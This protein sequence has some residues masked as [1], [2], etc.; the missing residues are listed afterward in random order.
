M[1]RAG[2]RFYVMGVPAPHSPICLPQTSPLS[3]GLVERATACVDTAG[4]R[5]RNEHIVTEE[6]CCT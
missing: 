4:E 3:P 5:S 1:L 6:E 2:V